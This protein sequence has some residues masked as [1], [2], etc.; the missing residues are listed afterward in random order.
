MSWRTPSE[1]ASEVR[2]TFPGGCKPSVTMQHGMLLPVGVATTDAAAVAARG[3]FAAATG[4]AVRVAHQ[5]DGFRSCHPPGWCTN[6]PPPP[7]PPPPRR[8]PLCAAA[9]TA[10]R[11]GSRNGGGR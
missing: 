7:P 2:T 11:V 6:P 10:A 5:R 9:V 8:L 1:G 3:V 4:T